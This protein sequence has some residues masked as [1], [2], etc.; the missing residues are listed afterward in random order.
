[1]SS[2]SPPLEAQRFGRSQTPESPRP[3]HIPEPANIPVLMN[4]M[5]PVFNDTATYNIPHNQTFS[6][7]PDSASEQVMQSAGVDEQDAVQNFFREAEHQAAAEPEPTVTTTQN[8]SHAPPTLSVENNMVP[9]EPKPDEST[10]LQQDFKTKAHITSLAEPAA[11]DGNVITEHRDTSRNDVQMED[12]TIG[13]ALIRAIADTEA[14]FHAAEEPT[15]ANNTDAGVDYQS[16]L[17]TISQSASTAPAA[18]TLTVSTT[19]PPLVEDISRPLASI[20]GLPPKPPPQEHPIEFPSYSSFD[21]ASNQQGSLKN[22]PDL[23]HSAILQNSVEATQGSPSDQT[24]GQDQFALPYPPPPLLTGYT[25]IPA[26]NPLPALPSQAAPG[27]DANRNPD[28]SERQWSPRTQSLYDQFLEDERRYVTEGIWDR[29]PAGSRLFVGNLPSEKVTKRDLFHKFHR[30]GKLAQISIKQAYGFVQFLEAASCLAA[31]N[32]E[33]GVEIRGRKVH[34]EISK[35][36]KNTRNAASG[37][38]NQAR[39]RSRSPERG[40]RRDSRNYSDFRDEPG[41]RRDDFRRRSPSPASYRQR[42]DYR[43]GG[44]EGRSRSP[45]YGSSYAPQAPTIDDETSLQLPRRD[46]RQVPDVQLLVLEAEVVQSFINWV[47][48]GFRAKGLQASTIWV[49]N[50]LPLPAVIKRQIIEGVQAVVKLT[51]ASQNNSKIPLQVFDRSAGASNVNFNEYVDLDINI[52]A[53]VVLQARQKER[54]G[55]IQG[56]RPQSFPPQT[57]QPQPPAQYGAP[58]PPIPYSQQA[59]APYSPQPGQQ[60]PYI[61]AG[62][63]QSGYRPPTQPL[64]PTTAQPNLQQLLANLRQP[65]NQPGPQAM[66]TNQT[67]Q[68]TNLSGFLGNLAGQPQYAQGQQPT[69]GQYGVNSPPQG[70]Q[71]PNMQNIM[72]QLARYQR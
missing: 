53:D 10:T 21:N 19:A 24:P 8:P 12:Q 2:T 15:V 56:L 32:A 14:Q 28:P 64:T 9:S 60:Q 54:G 18:E 17:D 1:M 48:Q 61:Y 13:D 51:R 69:Y 66:G 16:L 41:R 38:K 27:Q 43:P 6:P 29:F 20:P 49:N 72:E 47:E 67:S 22:A 26:T 58:P 5:D 35:P 45:F 50:R 65:T 52:A 63:Q 39:R 33:Q 36:Q 42:D 3:V 46:P 59:M 70:S 71:Q 11:A 25:Q 40:A 55:S 7:F 23:Q 30:H 4:Q 68:P 31:L 44:R 34:L 57:Y 62:T 37:S